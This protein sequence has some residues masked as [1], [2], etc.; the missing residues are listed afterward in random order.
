MEAPPQ[1][2][3]VGAQPG[4]GQ[5]KASQHRD[6]CAGP[7]SSRIEHMLQ[8][9]EQR[10]SNGRASWS[11]GFD[12]AAKGVSAKR[13]FFGQ[14]GDG[15]RYKIEQQQTEG[16]RLRPELDRQLSRN[17]KGQDGEYHKAPAERCAKSPFTARGAALWQAKHLSQRGA[18]IGNRIKDGK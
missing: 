13:Y 6:Q 11:D 15:E 16:P 1:P 8:P 9:K 14:R 12:Q 3:T 17:R 5:Q 2:E 10:E 4:D 18:A 7:G